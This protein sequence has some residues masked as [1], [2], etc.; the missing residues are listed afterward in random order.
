MVDCDSE[1]PIHFIEG[2]YQKQT[3][4]GYDVVNFNISKLKP[5]QNFKHLFDSKLP[6]HLGTIY[7]AAANNVNKAQ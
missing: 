2:K 3:Q 7:G 5:R 6:H 4:D 1:A